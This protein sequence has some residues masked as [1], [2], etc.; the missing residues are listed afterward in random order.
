MSIG[1]D[2]Y[3]TKPFSEEE[4]IDAINGG[5]GTDTLRLGAAEF[6][7]EAGY[8]LVNISQVESITAV[9]TSRQPACWSSVP[10]WPAPRRPGK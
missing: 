3:I 9:A 10:A 8:T 7:L 2:D 1:A 6:T 4:I 5:A